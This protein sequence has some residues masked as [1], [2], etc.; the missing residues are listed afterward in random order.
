[1]IWVL[2]VNWLSR[3]ASGMRFV[4]ALIMF[5]V[6]AAS[7]VDA[8]QIYRWVDENGVVHYSDQPREDGDEPASVETVEI[9]VPPGIQ[10]PSR[11]VL[12]TP[13]QGNDPSAVNQDPFAA[14]AEA[15]QSD[16]RSAEI[17]APT[18][19]QVLW[20]LATRLPVRVSV[21][22]ALASSDQIQ[23]LLDGQPIGEPISTTETVVQPVYRGEHT[24]SANIIDSTGTIIFVGQPITF[25]VQQAAVGGP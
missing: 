11:V 7:S 9:D 18:E 16:Y 22:P 17:I 15:T 19:Q 12:S 21:D 4:L 13:A 2:A 25:Y 8:Q 20:N 1:M 10:N 24:I 14:A 23:I 3:Y 5:G 6:F